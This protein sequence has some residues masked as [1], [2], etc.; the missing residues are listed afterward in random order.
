MDIP[1]VRYARNGDVSIAYSVTGEG[2]IDLVYIPGYIS[3]VEYMWEGER[4]ARFLHRLSSFS[5]LL[6]VD[7]RGTG[8]SDR[9]SP[10]DLPPLEIQMD[11]LLTVLD[12]VGSERPALFGFEAGAMLCAVFAATFPERTL[13]TVLYGTA[14]CGT[15]RPDYPWQWSEEEYGVYLERL[16]NGW[17]TKAYA[18]EILRWVAPSIGDDRGT[19]AWWA[20][21][22]RLA[23][24]P[25]SALALE[26][27]WSQ[28]DVRSVLGSI[29]APT[30]VAHR[31]ADPAEEIAG[32]RYIAERVP[33]ASLVELPGMD[34]PPWGDDQDALLDAVEQFLTGARHGPETD[35]VLATVLFT[36]IVGSTSKAAQLGDAAWKEILATHDDRARA[37]LDRFRGRFV[38]TTGDGLLA[39]FDGPARA[40]G[41]AQAIAEAVDPLGIEIRAG[42]HTGEIELARNEVRGLS[43]H[44]GARV[45]A[46]AGPGEVLVSST[47]KDLTAGSGLTFEDAGEHELKGVPDRWHLYRV[48]S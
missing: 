40:V 4:S 41:C 15:R 6:L 43:V 39:T 35:R 28:T 11:D 37:A 14:A 45:A 2:S 17:G 13:A 20:R 46:L 24:S 27:M 48:V 5:R 31:T 1:E 9:L 30:L 36:D 23:A 47:V 16:R 34:T 42:V 32:A 3:H 26:R 18:D 7:R 25:S 38:N 12:A 33:G 10:D 29:Q 19:R 21:L 22:H 44:I 8:L